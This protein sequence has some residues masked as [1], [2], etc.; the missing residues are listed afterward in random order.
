[1]MGPAAATRL[2]DTLRRLSGISC[3]ECRHTALG[4][5]VACPACGS[6]SLVETVFRPQGVLIAHTTCFHLSAPHQSQRSRI[7]GIVE[8]TDGPRFISEITDWISVSLAV[9]QPGVMV[10]RRL[11]TPP[12]DSVICYGYKFRPDIE[13]PCL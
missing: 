8:L 4:P 5:C 6:A 11:F 10:I 2:Q 12:P 7:Y 9:R 13:T 1:M 3:Q